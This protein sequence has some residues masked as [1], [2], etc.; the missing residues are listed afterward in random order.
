MMLQLSRIR[1]RQ[2]RQADGVEKVILAKPSGE[3]CAGDIGA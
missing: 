1:H 2:P 3:E